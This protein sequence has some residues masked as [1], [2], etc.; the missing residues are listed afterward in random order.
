VLKQSFLQCH[1]AKNLIPEAG[2]Q[3]TRTGKAVLEIQVHAHSCLVMFP[4]A[5]CPYDQHET[6]SAAV[7]FLSNFLNVSCMDFKNKHFMYKLLSA[8]IYV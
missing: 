4:C 5:V 8:K 2:S 3:P 6:C 1:K 7:A